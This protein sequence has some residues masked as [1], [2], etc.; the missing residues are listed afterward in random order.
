MLG[1]KAAKAVVKGDPEAAGIVSKGT[2]QK[3]H[4]FTESIKESLPGKKD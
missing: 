1:K 4:E 3:V 2:K